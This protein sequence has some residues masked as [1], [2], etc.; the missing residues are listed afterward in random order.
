MM[1]EEPFVLDPRPAFVPCGTAA[2]SAA[3]LGNPEGTV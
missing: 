3:V 1:F 2:N